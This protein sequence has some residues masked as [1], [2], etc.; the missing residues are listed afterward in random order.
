MKSSFFV[1]LSPYSQYSSYDPESG[2]KLQTGEGF[3]VRFGNDTLCGF[4]PDT[5]PRMNCAEAT[6]KV[7]VYI[8]THDVPLADHKAAYVTH[9]RC[10]YIYSAVAHVGYYRCKPF[11][12]TATL[13]SPPM[14]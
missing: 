10:L 4:D 3:S 12:V 5:S 11:T 1:Q 9:R 2:G 13:F 8:F 7:M 6:V 14:L